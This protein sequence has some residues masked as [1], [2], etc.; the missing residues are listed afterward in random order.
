[1]KSK[2]KVVVSIISVLAT[3]CIIAG[4]V[5]LY[6]RVFNV[7]KN[8]TE[9]LYRQNVSYVG[10]ENTVET[11]FPQTDIYNIIKEHF[12]SELPEGKTKKK[13]VVIG[14]DGCRADILAEKQDDTKLK[15]GSF[16]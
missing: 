13:V 1:M 4:G 10:Y 2:K 5:T 12:T 9:A 6:V 11:A 15:T 7:G 8:D 16:L 3:L 14:Y